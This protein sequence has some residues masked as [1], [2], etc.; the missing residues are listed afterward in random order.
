MPLTAVSSVGLPHYWFLP[1]REHEHRRPLATRFV[2]LCAQAAARYDLIY[3]LLSI[4]QVR[5]SQ[6][7][8]ASARIM[9]ARETG[10][11]IVLIACKPLTFST[12]VPVP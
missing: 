7:P 5:L 9:K 1:I 8:N 11:S 2:F 10:G 6:N 12:I 4:A 3:F